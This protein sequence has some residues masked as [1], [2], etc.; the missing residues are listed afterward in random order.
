MSI[1]RRLAVL[2]LLG[3][4]F[5]VPM[6]AR[7]DEPVRVF[8]AASLKNALDDVGAAWKAETGKSMVA[9][10]AASPALAKQ[11]EQGA[12]AD[13]FISADLDWMDHLQGKGLIRPHTR[14]N[15]FGAGLFCWRG[16]GIPRRAN[17]RSCA[18]WPTPGAQALNGP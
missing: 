5:W 17:P 18:E 12:P 14:V 9:S 6:G 13:L 11:I 7:A 2:V 10:Y 4:G 8:A 1:S 15:L 3:M 16:A